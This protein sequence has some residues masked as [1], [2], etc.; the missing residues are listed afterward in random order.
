MPTAVS[1]PVGRAIN[2]NVGVGMHDI[3]M[4]ASG[5]GWS[6]ASIAARAGGTRAAATPITSALTLIAVCATAND[7]VTLPPAV[8]GQVVWVFN[9]GAASA[10]VYAANG[11]SDTISGV[12]AATGV[13]LASGKGE[14]FFSPISGAWFGVLSA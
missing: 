9:G 11:T 8:G 6:A 14:T 1:Y 3:S 7:S 5:N 10:Q 2:F 12:A 13:A 4:L